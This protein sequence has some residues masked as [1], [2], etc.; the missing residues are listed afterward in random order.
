VSAVEIGGQSLIDESPIPL[1]ASSQYTSMSL[2]AITLSTWVP[3]HR[4]LV[5]QIVGASFP[6]LLV[7]TLSYDAA[8][9]SSMPVMPFVSPPLRITSPTES[10][11]QSKF[12]QH[13]QRLR[14]Q[15]DESIQQ[16]VGFRQVR[17][18]HVLRALAS[19]ASLC[20]LRAGPFPPFH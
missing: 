17:G 7:E 5:H 9:A 12:H 10:E 1:H 6:H 16:R 2:R 13:M 4:Q 18:E 19:S 15:F 3:L 8:E 20:S 14:M 11:R